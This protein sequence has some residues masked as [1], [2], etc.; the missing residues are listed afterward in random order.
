MNTSFKNLNLQAQLGSEQK[1]SAEARSCVPAGPFWSLQLCTAAIS[2]N[3]VGSFLGPP[4]G[5][6]L[7]A[8]QWRVG[9]VQ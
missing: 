4:Q 3:M 9:M 5:S 6:P 7:E 2:K 1:S 8:P